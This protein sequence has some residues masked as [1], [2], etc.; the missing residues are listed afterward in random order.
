MQS[1][2]MQTEKNGQAAV[3]SSMAP[4]SCFWSPIWMVDGCAPPTAS[5]APSGGRAVRRVHQS[6]LTV[7]RPAEVD[8]AVLTGV[9][10]SS[11]KTRG[12]VVA[13]RP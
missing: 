3:L 11:S 9:L 7:V 8:S 4:S 13:R 10:A 5:A 12:S 6:L 1:V 2:A